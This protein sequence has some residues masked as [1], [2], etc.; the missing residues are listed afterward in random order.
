MKTALSFLSWYHFLLVSAGL[1]FLI[2]SCLIWAL[3]RE[4]TPAKRFPWSIILLS[5]SALCFYS[6]AALLDPFLNPWDER[7]HALVAKNLLQHPFTFTLYDDPVMQM[8]YDRWDRSVIWLHKPPLFLWMIALIYK[9]FGVSWFTTR[10]PSIILCSLL[11]PVTYRTGKLLA[12]ESTGFFSALFAATSFSLL[13]LVSGRQPVDHCDVS[14]LFFVSASLWSWV[15]GVSSGNKRWVM[16][17]GLFAGMAV[18]SKWLPGLLVYAVWMVYAMMDKKTILKNIKQAGAAFLITLI[19]VV[20][21]QIYTWFRYP[22]EAQA[23]TGYSIRHFNTGLEGHGMNGWYYFQQIDQQYGPWMFLLI[24]AG[25]ITFFMLSQRKKLSA[26]FLAGTVF[27]YLFFSLAKTKMPSYTMVVFMSVVILLGTLPAM[28]IRITD[29]WRIAGW[30]P[31]IL[32]FVMTIGITWYNIRPK[33]IAETYLP[34][35]HGWYRNTMISNRNE[36][37]QWKKSLPPNTVI[38]NVPGRHYIECMFYTGHPSYG[39]IPSEMQYQGLRKQGYRVALVQPVE[40]I[41]PEYLLQPGDSLIIG[42]VIYP[43]E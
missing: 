15:E 37:M 23:E 38:C 29:R 28:I 4:K 20:P 41:L 25:L 18:L 36:L 24:P 40:G 10:I 11:V 34:G 32:C 39:F 14:F 26:A 17:T 22:V 42:P 12:G 31:V 27:V 13:G 8:A 30:F 21:W 16:L 5:L 7:F 1:V 9:F 6:F 35:G 43:C 33:Q 2:L 19:T 3:N